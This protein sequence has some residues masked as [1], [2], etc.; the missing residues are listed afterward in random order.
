MYEFNFAIKKQTKHYLQEILVVINITGLE[1]MEKIQS[2]E[3]FFIQNI[4]YLFI[5]DKQFS[6]L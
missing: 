4:F 3:S 5:F 2:Q 6:H 1:Q